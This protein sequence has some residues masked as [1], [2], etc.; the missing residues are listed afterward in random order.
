[1]SLGAKHD[2]VPDRNH[3]SLLAKLDQSSLDVEMFLIPGRLMGSFGTSKAV[4]QRQASLGLPKYKAWGFGMQ[5]DLDMVVQGHIEEF[6][7]RIVDC[8]PPHQKL[9]SYLFLALKY[10]DGQPQICCDI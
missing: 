8:K 2:N 5:K 6:R 1:M 7:F 4:T 9:A 10:P 3:L